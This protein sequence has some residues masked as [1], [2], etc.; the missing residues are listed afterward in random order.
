[1]K[2]LGVFFYLTLICVLL[3]VGLYIYVPSSYY[4]GSVILL[5]L[6][7]AFMLKQVQVWRRG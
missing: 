1:M 3:V 7:V 6:A 4:T 2:K 5:L